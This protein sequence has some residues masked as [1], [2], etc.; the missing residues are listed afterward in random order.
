MRRQKTSCVKK[1]MG[2]H[3]SLYDRWFWPWEMKQH[4]QAFFDI[5]QYPQVKLTCIMLCVTI[6]LASHTAA[7][8]SRLADQYF[9]FVWNIKRKLN[10]DNIALALFNIEGKIG[11]IWEANQ[12]HS[13]GPTRILISSLTLI[14]RWFLISI[15]YRKFKMLI[16]VVFNNKV[17][18]ETV[19]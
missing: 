16:Q 3:Q 1:K 10:I 15:N 2:F 11:P 5:W 4:G 6:T 9:R 8:L 14:G 12:G 7:I 13:D 19:R 18:R 17:F